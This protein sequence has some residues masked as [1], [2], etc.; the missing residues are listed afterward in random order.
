MY[1]YVTLTLECNLKCKYCYGKCWDE[2]D[3][4]LDEE[5]ID[6][7]LP[8]AISYGINELRGFIGRDPYPT[9][10]F[11]GGEPLLRVDLME[12]IMDRVPARRFILQTNGLLLDR[13]ENEYLS[14]LDSILV[15]I[16]GSRELT[17]FYRGDGV[18]M[19]IVENVR[20]I[21]SMGFKGE[22]IARMTVSNNTMELEREV[23]SLIE[24]EDA[25]FDSI[26]WQLDALFWKGDYDEELIGEW[27]ENYNIHVRRLAR[28]WVMDMILSGRVLRIYPL[29]GVARSLLLNEQS[30]LRCGAGWVMFNIQ[31][32]GRITPC[33]VM[34]GMRRFYLGDIHSLNPRSLRDSVSVA[35]PCPSCRIYWICGG[36]C[37]YAN[38]TRLWGPEGYR[39]VCRTV[40]NLVESMRGF[41]PVLRRL[42]WEG[43]IGIGEFNYPRFNSCEIIP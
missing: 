8:G 36:R 10:V 25:V 4:A 41:I 37:L 2:P 40:E 33:P 29:L 32:D 24:G 21:R 3:Y 6:Y 13:L 30:K 11:Y 20:R 23:L 17:D 42:L 14:R 5:D 28:I 16:D 15:S 43:R 9:I 39:M 35:N 12:E 19:K 18:Y 22:I 34:A 31:T 7:D 26:H 1:Y 27:L 38:S